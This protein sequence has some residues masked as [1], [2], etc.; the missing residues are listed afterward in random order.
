MAKVKSVRLT[1]DGSVENAHGTMI[2]KRIGLEIIREKC[3]HFDNWLSIIE[4]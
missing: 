2:T 1:Y 3:P 4:G